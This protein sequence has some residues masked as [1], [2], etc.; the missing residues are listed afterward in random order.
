MNRPAAEFSGFAY[1]IHAVDKDA[2][3]TAA[4]KIFGGRWNS[5]NRFGLLYLSLTKKTAKAEYGTQL[6]K[7]GLR[8]EDV[9]PR[10]ISKIHVRLTR[11]LDLTNPESQKEFGVTERELGSDDKA[12]LEKILEVSERARTQGFEAILSPSARLSGGK[13]LN[14]FVDR[15]G[16]KSFVKNVKSEALKEENF[17]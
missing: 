16:P 12:C 3:D 15:L 9:S 4:S 14:I 11:V 5:A 1:R 6:S 2:L 10:L 7:R 13:N 17:D 8:P